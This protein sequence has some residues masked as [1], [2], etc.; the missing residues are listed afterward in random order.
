MGASVNQ[1]SLQQAKAARDRA[2]RYVK[3][4]PELL[5]LCEDEDGETGTVVLLGY[6]GKVD[7]VPTVR[8]RIPRTCDIY[9]VALESL[10]V[11]AET[12]AHLDEAAAA[13]ESGPIRGQYSQGVRHFTHAGSYR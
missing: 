6:D 12:A 5:A 3:Q 9:R 2:S 7:G 4:K 10:L 13:M 1:L 11:D 8:V